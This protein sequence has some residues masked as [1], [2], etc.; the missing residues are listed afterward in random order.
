MR[1]IEDRMIERRDEDDRME[2]NGRMVKE[3]Q[4][5]RNQEIG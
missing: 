1:N 4:K 5:S 3:I 2:D